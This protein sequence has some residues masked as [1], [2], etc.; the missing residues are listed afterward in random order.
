MRGDVIPIE[1]RM[2]SPDIGGVRL[3]GEHISGGR[4][5]LVLRIVLGGVPKRRN[6]FGE[7]LHAPTATRAHHAD[8]VVCAGGV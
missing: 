4:V 8:E 3:E 7:A 5:V 6:H 1:P 2:Y